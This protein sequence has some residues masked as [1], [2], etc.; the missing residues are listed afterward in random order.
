M[1]PGAGGIECDIGGISDIVTARRGSLGVGMVE[2]AM[3]LKLN[4]EDLIRDTTA[5]GDL[6]KK[7]NDYIP[8]KRPPYPPAYFE[9]EEEEEGEEE[10]DT[11]S[12]AVDGGGDDE[13]EIQI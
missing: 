2:V 13:P 12:S 7:W 4:S 5:V 8:N 11:P 9:T 1:K 10:D 3:L 6:G